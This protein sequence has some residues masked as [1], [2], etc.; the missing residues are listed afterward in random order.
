MCGGKNGAQVKTNGKPKVTSALAKLRA[1]K[2]QIEARLQDGVDSIT[3]QQLESRLAWINDEI[4]R[5]R[6]ELSKIRIAVGSQESVV[7]YGH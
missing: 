3:R 6:D 2:L 4:G 1:E 7:I 5:I